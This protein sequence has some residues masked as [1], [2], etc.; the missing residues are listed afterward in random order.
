MTD[1]LLTGQ[2]L[3]L[4]GDLTRLSCQAI[5][6]PT[7]R[8]LQVTRGW[9]DVVPLRSRVPNSIGWYDVEVS[10]PPGWGDHD[11]ALPVPVDDRGRKVWLARTDAHGRVAAWVVESLLQAVR[12][13]ASAL[14]P[15]Q[16]RALR[17]IGVP[18]AGT[19]DG[20]STMTRTCACRVRG[21]GQRTVGQAGRRSAT[22]QR[23]ARGAVE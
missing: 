4:H 5:V 6:V 13:A 15:S 19:G 22:E 3:V 7:S 23:T 11:R 12:R 16:A 14:P 17:L 20:A 21:R 18:L 1:E 2:L 9:I 10:A 8:Q